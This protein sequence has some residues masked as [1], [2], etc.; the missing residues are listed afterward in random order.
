MSKIEK[1]L[2]SG[3]THTTVSAIAPDG[4]VNVNLQLSSPDGENQVYS[5]VPNHPV[6]ERLFA[7]AWSSC[8]IGA[9]GIVAAQKRIT[10]PKDLSVDITVDL[11]QSGHE[12]LLQAMFEIRMPGIDRDVVEKLAHKAHEICPYSKAVHGNI[13]VGLNVIE[14]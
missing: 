12:Y 14:S 5:D 3:T 2:F 9:L 1:V 8:Y 6:A 10:L 11:V 13:K 4:H 7:G